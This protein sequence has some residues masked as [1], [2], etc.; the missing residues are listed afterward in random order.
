MQRFFV[1]RETGGRVKAKASMSESKHAQMGAILRD[2]GYEEV[3]AGEYS[4]FVRQNPLSKLETR[5]RIP[6][7]NSQGGKPV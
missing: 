7:S 1:N 2:A 3:S 5:S 4:Q 6:A